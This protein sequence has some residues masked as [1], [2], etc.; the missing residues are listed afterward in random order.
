[1]S[2]VFHS[3]EIG[4]R[5]KTEV[6]KFHAANAK[7]TSGPH[8]SWAKRVIRGIKGPAD[9]VSTAKNR[10]PEKRTDGVK[11]LTSNRRN[12]LS[13]ELSWQEVSSESHRQPS[14]VRIS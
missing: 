13:A 4:A 11:F 7:K 14:P 8:L 2:S 5:E 10:G 1:M 9:F 6:E 12:Q 3:L